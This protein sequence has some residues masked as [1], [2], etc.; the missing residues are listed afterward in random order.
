MRCSLFPLLNNNFNNKPR[1]VCTGCS[2]HMRHEQAVSGFL[3]L[4]FFTGFTQCTVT[5]ESSNM[6]GLTARE[7]PAPGDKCS[8]SS[9]DYYPSPYLPHPLAPEYTMESEELVLYPQGPA[10]YQGNLQQKISASFCSFGPL[11]WHK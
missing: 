3:I 9:S 6:P 11:E 5:R 1:S 8:K 4:S 2:K 7:Y 10:S